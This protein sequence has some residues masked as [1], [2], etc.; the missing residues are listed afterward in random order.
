[1][2]DLEELTLPQLN[3]INRALHT[4]L[5]YGKESDNNL[6]LELMNTLRQIR[7]RRALSTPMTAERHDVFYP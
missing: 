7:F 1:M 2:A 3:L 5:E 4:H 6:T